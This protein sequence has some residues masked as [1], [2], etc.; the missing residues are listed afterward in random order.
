[1]SGPAA[2]VVVASNRAAAGVYADTSGPILV[3]GLRGL[4]FVVPDPV[5]VADGGPVGDALREAVAAGVAL[6]VTSG[7]TG[8]TPTD[9]TPDVTR[10]LLDYEIPG[11]AEAIRAHSRAT[12]PTAALSRGRAGVAGRTL[13]VNLPGSTGGARDGLAVL[14]PIVRHA[15]EQ[16]AGGDH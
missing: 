1:M 10:D 14:G 7:G 6:V 4:G 5:V 16:L 11:I 2:R 9:R 15:I 12:V 3:E 8:I 13:I